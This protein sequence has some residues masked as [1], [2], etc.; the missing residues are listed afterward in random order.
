[1]LTLYPCILERYDYFQQEIRAKSLSRVPEE[2]LTED[3][4]ICI[5]SFWIMRYHEPLK[6]RVRFYGFNIKCPPR[7]KGLSSGSHR[8]ILF[9]EVLETCKNGAGVKDICH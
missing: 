1:M 6:I 9:S 3:P 2:T 4:R 7:D 8:M 5:T